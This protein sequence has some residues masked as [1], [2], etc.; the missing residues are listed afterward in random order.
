L[1]R[2][3]ILLR[4]DITQAVPAEVV[5][6]AYAMTWIGPWARQFLLDT[7]RKSR[8]RLTPRQLAKRF[9]LNAHILAHIDPEPEVLAGINTR[10]TH[11]TGEGVQHA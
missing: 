4:D 8:K 2:T 11:K 1:V 7:C 6:Y 3:I 5:E 9:H 10:G